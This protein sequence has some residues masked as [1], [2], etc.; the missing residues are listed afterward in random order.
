ML[1]VVSGSRTCSTLDVDAAAPRPIGSGMIP[2]ASHGCRTDDFV[3][4]RY[5]QSVAS[6]SA[7]CAA[8]IVSTSCPDDGVA[9]SVT[10][11]RSTSASVRT[12]HVIVAPVK[13]NG[14]SA[15]STMS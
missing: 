7:V 10:S 6:S 9:V 11:V 3:T 14:A 4:S 8:D 12:L 13:S 1:S 2:P 15:E 5:Q